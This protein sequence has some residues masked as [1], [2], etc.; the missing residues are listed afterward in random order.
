[1]ATTY[2][3]DIPALDVYTHK[4]GRDDVVFNVH[5]SCVGEELGFTSK[6]YGTCAVPPATEAFTPYP[7]LTKDEVL[8]WIWDNG[9]HKQDTEN[10]VQAQLQELITPTVQTPPLPW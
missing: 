7:D 10:Q 9:V 3:W 2:T 6:I 5:W 8:R 4:D 1:M